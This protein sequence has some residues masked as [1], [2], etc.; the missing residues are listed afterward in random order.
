MDLG[1]SGWTEFTMSP[2]VANYMADNPELFMCDMGLIHSHH[3]MGAFFSGQDVNT[4]QEEGDS[5]NCF[6][7]LIVDTRGT[8]QAAITRKI[9]TK[10][11]VTTKPLGTSYE[12]FGDGPVSTTENTTSELSTMVVDTA[13]IEY[14][15]LDVEREEVTNSLAYLDD[16][17]NVIEQ[18]K[19]A[20]TAFQVKPVTPAATINPVN[21]LTT[22]QKKYDEKYTGL[23]NNDVADDYWKE[24]METYEPAP[25]PKP[26]EPTLWDEKTMKDLEKKTI[27]DYVPDAALIHRV[28]VQMVTCCLNINVEK[29]DLKNWIAKHMVKRYEALF[30]DGDGF[31][32]WKDFIID[33]IMG[34]FYDESVFELCGDVLEPDDNEIFLMTVASAIRE[35][36]EE[37]KGSNVYIDSY[38]KALTCYCG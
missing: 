23:W 24:Y 31:D 6:V 37:F 26:K 2:E 9:E 15:M 34:H 32:E 17:F 12:F 33:F 21:P 25:A 1:T 11:E 16:R 38:I 3:N 20:A 13:I 36:L 10:S 35:E 4:L 8:Y 29:L 28:V 19:K 7:S 22:T 5:T 27:M 18:R 14:F 30:L